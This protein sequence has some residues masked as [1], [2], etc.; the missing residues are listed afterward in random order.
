MV[1]VRSAVDARAV[2]RAQFKVNHYVLDGTIADCV[3]EVAGKPL[4]GANIHTISTIYAHAL[5]SE[6]YMV[7]QVGH[8]GP[9][10]LETGGWGVRLGL[11]DVEQLMKAAPGSTAF[12]LGLLRE[13]AAAVRAASERFFDETT[14]ENLARLVDSYLGGQVPVAEYH[15]IFA[16]T[17]L[18]EHTGE[19]AALKGVHGLQGLPF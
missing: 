10:L 6:D 9:L 1:N 13:Y 4:A 8:G 19:I 11:A 3:Q 15:A 17:H 2:L 16:V 7:N 14:E 12:D 5:S 18:A